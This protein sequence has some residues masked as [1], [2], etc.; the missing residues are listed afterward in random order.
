MRESRR[1][2][3]ARERQEAKANRFLGPD[4]PWHRP[5]TPEDADALSRRFGY[6]YL[7]HVVAEDGSGKIW[8]VFEPLEPGDGPF[9][10]AEARPVPQC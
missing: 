8:T 6:R 10:I 7:C 1:D 4:G 2:R 3:R 9:I 5:L